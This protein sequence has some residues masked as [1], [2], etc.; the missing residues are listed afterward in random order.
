MI[1]LAWLIEG[2][3][4]HVRILCTS[5]SAVCA[6]QLHHL[7]ALCVMSC[8]LDAALIIQEIERWGANR[9]AAIVTDNAANM[10]VAR[11]LVLEKFPKMVDVRYF[12]L[13]ALKCC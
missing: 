7:H 12:R 4:L 5:V 10:V 1:C 6:V 3:T 2:R 9:F 11:P 13:K 8:H